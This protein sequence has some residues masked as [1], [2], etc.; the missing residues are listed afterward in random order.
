MTNTE[1]FL[2]EEKSA[3]NE[4]YYA[5]VENVLIIPLIVLFRFVMIDIMNQSL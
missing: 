5:D 1:T 3:I 4:L 2:R